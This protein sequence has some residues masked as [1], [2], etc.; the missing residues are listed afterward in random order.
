MC[1]ALAGVNALVILLVPNARVQM[2][3]YQKLMSFGLPA[4]SPPDMSVMFTWIGAS[5]LV[6]TAVV[7]VYLV[8]RRPVFELSGVSST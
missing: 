2:A 1:L 6:F 4:Q 3:A 5:S 7:I 8:R